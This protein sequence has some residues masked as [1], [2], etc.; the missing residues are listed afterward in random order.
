[1][2]KKNPQRKKKENKKKKVADTMAPGSNLSI[3]KIGS[4]RHCS[5]AFWNQSGFDLCGRVVVVVCGCGLV[6]LGVLFQ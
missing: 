4:T 1:M 5:F 6:Y 2:M 3:A